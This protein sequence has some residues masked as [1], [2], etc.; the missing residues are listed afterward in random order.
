MKQ[1][2]IILHSIWD[3][4]DK[5]KTSD[6]ILHEYIG[7]LQHYD[8]P[9]YNTVRFME[10]FNITL[11]SIWGTLWF[12]HRILPWHG[13]VMGFLVCHRI[14][15]RHGR[16][17]GFLVILSQ[18]SSLSWASYGV[19]GFLWLCHRIVPCHGWVMGFLVIMFTE[20]FPVMGELWGVQWL[21]HRIDLGLPM[22][23]QEEW[24]IWSV[25]QNNRLLCIFD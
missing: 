8:S 11:H 24:E 9:K 21:C 12:C 2:N 23:Y 17:T 19:S 5:A 10:Q 20:L 25:T 18:N 7:F 4:N 1:F 6:Y 14:V 3:G 16:V 15:P 13:R 22:Y